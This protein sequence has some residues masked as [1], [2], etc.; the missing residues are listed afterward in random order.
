MSNNNYVDHKTNCNRCGTVMVSGWTLT[1]PA[2]LT[3]EKL[4]EQNRILSQQASGEGGGGGY[5]GS[6]SD[7]APP[8]Y[9]L[10]VVFSAIF[11]WILIGFLFF[12]H[13]GIV[14]FVKFVGTVFLVLGAFLLAIPVFLWEVLF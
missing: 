6:V 13:W 10:Y 7:T 3:N 14:T 4:E 8:A 12:P 11:L 2:C 5:G 9:A 1:C